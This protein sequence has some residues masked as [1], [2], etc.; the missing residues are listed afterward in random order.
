M[1]LIQEETRS[2]SPFPTT[3]SPT[4]TMNLIINADLSKDTN[5]VNASY[6]SDPTVPTPGSVPLLPGMK[7]TTFNLP[8]FIPLLTERIRTLNSFTRMF[9]IQWISVLDSIPDLELISYLPD[10]LDGLFYYLSDPNIDVRVATLNVLGEFLK[11]IH[12]VVAIQRERGF[13]KLIG[14]RDSNEHAAV[15][16]QMTSSQFEQPL[17]RQ[18]QGVISTQQLSISQTKNFNADDVNDSNSIATYDTVESEVELNT[19]NISPSLPGTTQLSSLSAESTYAKHI[20]VETSSSSP[21]IP[22]LN[23]VLDIGRMVD[24][25]SPHLVSAD[26]ETQATALRWMNDFILLIG[27]PIMLTFMPMLL[28][29]VL[30]YLSHSVSPIKSMAIEL[31]AN[32]Y[33]LVM[34]TTTIPSRLAM[35]EK[36]G[37]S[38]NLSSNDLSASVGSL[39]LSSSFQLSEVIDLKATVDVLKIQFE[40]ESEETRVAGMEWLLMLH[41]RASRKVLT[42]IFNY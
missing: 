21:Y 12:D 29:A 16:H 27:A 1:P 35:P 26:E 13:L 33:R 30:P 4:Q 24:I 20:V 22:G 8:R 38:L 23:V 36:G 37:N 28:G 10:F 25:L 5:T 31:N 17:Q 32:L 39:S 42:I 14:Q 19:A 15:T 40:D 6:P 9:L 41:K 11:E 34:D 7:P 18:T 2:S 3:I